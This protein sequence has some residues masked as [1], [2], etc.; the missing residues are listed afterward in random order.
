MSSTVHNNV[1]NKH[2]YSI[3][4]CFRQLA[5]SLM[6]AFVWS[7]AF[8]QKPI[9]IGEQFELDSK[10]LGEKR[11]INVYY[12]EG[13]NPDSAKL[14]PVI[15]LLDGGMDED[16]L[17][18][19]G[20]VQFCNFPWVGFLEPS[21]VVGIP[22]TDR[23]RDL[24]FPPSKNFKFPEGINPKRFEKMGGSGA[25]LDFIEKE[26]Q[27]FIRSHCKA[28]STQSIVG[29]SLAGLFIAEILIKKTELFQNYIIVS[30]SM[31]WDNESLLK[32]PLGPVSFKAKI[33]IAVGKEGEMMEGGAQRLKKHVEEKLG[34][35][36]KIHFEYLPD[37]N[38][39]TIY[40]QAV[41]NAF[42]K[43]RQ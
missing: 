17:N 22:N 43:F 37:E 9:A 1:I 10:F 42:R 12:P 35:N 33:Y 25:F 18:V 36:A 7:N 20:T 21:I 40:H 39:A 8:G 4:K 19:V 38:H 5:F 11:S 14:Y 2:C 27:P 3:S 29:Q 16:F 15:Y 32:L 13:Y 30:P 6:L 28:N 23:Q 31:W 24:T 34:P 41:Y 26:L